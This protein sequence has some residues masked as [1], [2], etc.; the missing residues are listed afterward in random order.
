M[1]PTIYSK[2]DALPAP[3]PI[4]CGF[5]FRDVSFSYPG[6]TRL[7]LDRLNFTLH[8]GERVALIGENGEGKTTIVKLLTRL[9]D[10]TAARYFSMAW[11]FANT[12][13]KISI[14]RS[15]LSFRISCAMR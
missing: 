11:T 1:Q 2:P 15:E 14:A 8:P 3:R 5:E 13:S 9:Y 7:V 4:V 10:P 12:A 6:S